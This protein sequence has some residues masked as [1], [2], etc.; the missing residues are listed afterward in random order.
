MIRLYGP[1]E[2]AHELGVTRAAIGNLMARHG[3]EL[4]KPYAF[5]DDSRV[6]KRWL[7]DAAGLNAWLAYRNPDKAK[8]SAAPQAWHDDAER[9]A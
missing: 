8:P 6:G 4:P 5:V 1:T 2:I 3:D 7:W 9:N